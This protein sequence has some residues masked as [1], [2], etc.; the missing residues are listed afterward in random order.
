MKEDEA[1]LA[2]R[3]AAEGGVVEMGKLQVTSQATTGKSLT[4]EASAK[5]TH[6]VQI[7]VHAAYR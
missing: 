7:P 2:R 1:D 3:Q 5:A 6:S 4:N